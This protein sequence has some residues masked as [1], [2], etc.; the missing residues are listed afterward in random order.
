MQLQEIN[1]SINVINF[2][3]NFSIFQSE[4]YYYTFRKNG[5]K[6]L[7][8]GIYELGS[9]RIIRYFDFCDRKTI[10]VECYEDPVHTYMVDADHFKKHIKESAMFQLSTILSGFVYEIY[11]LINHILFKAGIYDNSKTN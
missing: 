8:F 3:S 9:A 4:N 7:H 10:Y 2:D 11:E 5:N 6:I 1:Q